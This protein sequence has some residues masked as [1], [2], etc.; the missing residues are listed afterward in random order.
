MLTK[1]HDAN[2]VAY[3]DINVGRAVASDIN[4][5]CAVISSQI[6][7]KLLKEGNLQPFNLVTKFN[8]RT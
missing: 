6:L 1:F 8:G 5:D 3:K 4:V 2:V 7:G